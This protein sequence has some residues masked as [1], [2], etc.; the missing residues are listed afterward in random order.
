MF[1]NPYI[2]LSLMCLCFPG[3][4]PI[5]VTAFIARNFDFTIS[6]RERGDI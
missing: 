3:I 1:E 4:L 2:L 5:I 6:K